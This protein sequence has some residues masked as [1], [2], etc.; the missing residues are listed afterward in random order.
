MQTATKSI[1]PS[2]ATPTVEESV[3]DIP[4]SNA[5]ETRTVWV[6]NILILIAPM[7]VLEYELSFFHNFFL[8]RLPEK[9]SI[10]VKL[11]QQFRKLL[12][13]LQLLRRREVFLKTTRI[14]FLHIN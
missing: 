6:N 1:D 4:T 8:C 11:H 5:F 3:A 2:E 7:M 12:Q 9:A 10:R 14:I 13:N